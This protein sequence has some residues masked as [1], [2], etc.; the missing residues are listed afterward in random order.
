MALVMMLDD[1]CSMMLDDVSV[2]PEEDVDMKG[3]VYREPR[4]LTKPLELIEPSPLGCVNTSDASCRSFE[5]DFSVVTLTA[6]V[7]LFNTALRVEFNDSTAGDELVDAGFVVVVV[8]TLDVEDA[9]DEDNVVAAEMSAAVAEYAPEASVESPSPL[10]II[11]RASVGKVRGC[12]PFVGD[13]TCGADVDR[14]TPP[15]VEAPGGT[16]VA[17]CELEPL[18]P[19]V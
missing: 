1:V 5:S 8:S 14:L 13:T 19:K 2:R 18:K 9:E 16:N 7:P 6:R 11:P 15:S 4:V 10:I 17:P 3:V 12:S